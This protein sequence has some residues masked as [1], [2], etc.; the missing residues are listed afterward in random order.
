MSHH[1]STSTNHKFNVNIQF[2]NGFKK[3]NKFLQFLKQLQKELSEVNSKIS[4]FLTDFS[5]TSLRPNNGKQMSKPDMSNPWAFLNMTTKSYTAAKAGPD[6][7]PDRIFVKRNSLLTEMFKINHIRTIRNIFTSIM[8]LL[9][10]QVL[11]DELM[12]QG[13]L[14]IILKIFN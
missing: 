4:Q 3:L 10:L 14:V 1:E 13:K 11:F 12:D 2:F 6:D 5:K 7:L 9:A 8:L